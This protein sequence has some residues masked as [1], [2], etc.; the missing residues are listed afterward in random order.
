MTGT[1]RP[2][3]VPGL[4]N[5]IQAGSPLTRAP[6]GAGPVE[7]PRALPPRPVKPVRFTLDLDRERHQFLKRFALDAETDAAA[8]MRA[9]LSRLQSDPEL[10]QAI[11]SDIWER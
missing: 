4:R 1:R 9:L 5:A 11:R 8:V 10:A 3:G 2:S 7:A 6:G